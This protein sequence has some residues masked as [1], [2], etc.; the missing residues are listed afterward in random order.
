MNNI[1]FLDTETTG[2]NF[3]KDEIIQ[4]SA[5]RVD[6]CSSTIIDTMNIYI[7]ATAK[8]L[9]PEACKINGYYKN[10]WKKENKNPLNKKESAIEIYNYLTNYPNDV[11]FSHNSPFDR[12]FVITHILK[13]TEINE[14]CLPKYWYDTATI[15][16][17]FKYFLPDFKYTSLDYCAKQ[18][19]A[20]TIRHKEHDALQD[21]YI[22]KSVF[23]KMMK[24]ITIR[25]GVL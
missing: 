10:K 3:I 24:G 7:D 5:I 9:D 18:F 6:I 15:A 17:L 8:K 2:L 14:R 12:S 1:I 21:C 20:E 11:I 22:L 25:P 16:F 4:A 19:N 23:F 13:Y